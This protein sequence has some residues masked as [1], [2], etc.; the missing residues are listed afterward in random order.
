[1]NF[2]VEHFMF[3]YVFSSMI[4]KIKTVVLMLPAHSQFNHLHLKSCYSG[5]GKQC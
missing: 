5:S 4:H 2:T 3:I 1:M